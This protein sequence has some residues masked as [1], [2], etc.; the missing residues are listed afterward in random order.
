MLIDIQ[1][2]V[3]D[4]GKAMSNG[5]KK[6]HLSIAV[7]PIE[8]AD[9]A[10]SVGPFAK[11]TKR[12]L[13][14]VADAVVECLAQVP[15]FADIRVE[16]PFVNARFDTNTLFRLA[17][18]AI[19]EK[20]IATKKPERI[21]VEY[22]SPNTNKPLHLGHVRNGVL[23]STLANLLKAAGHHVVRAN[24]INDRGEHI[25]KSMLAYQRFGNGATP[26]SLGQKGD[27]FVGDCYVRY[28]QEADKDTSLAIEVAAMLKKWE[29]G[30]KEVRALW[31]M[32]NGWVYSGFAET[33]DRYGFS[34]DKVYHESLLF[35]LGKDKVDEGLAK[36]V[37]VR[38]DEGA[39]RFPLPV[40]LGLGA[41]GKQRQPKVLNAG[42]TSVYLT[43]DIGTAIMKAEE[44]NLDR[45]IYVVANEQ[46][47]HFMA[48]FEMLKA[49]GHTW[50][51]RCYHLSYA[52][53]ELPEGKMKSRTGRVVDADDLADDMA[54]LAADIIGQREPG[55]DAAEIAR[56]SEV[57]GLTA[58]KFY[59]MRYASTKTISFDPEKSISFEGDTGPYC[60]Y[61]YA[62]ARSILEKARTE[63]EGV[64]STFKPFTRL[65][66]I[67]ERGLALELL[68]LPYN[69][70]RAAD[71]Y[72]PSIL[73]ES[74]LNLAK[75]FNRF[76]KSAQVIS[77]D[78]SLTH[79]RLLL[80]AAAADGLKWGFSLMGIT[81]LE[82]M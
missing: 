59:L 80:V 23:G 5:E 70:R 19:A 49:L 82:K 67:E 13:G 52:M 39:V 36:G 8:K 20:N 48:L 60:L 27:H 16:G 74:M 14:E 4:I 73:V 79:E 26:L 66:S 53:V 2:S 6:A 21:M 68:R 22:L 11:N 51:S 61:T 28:A 40:H 12:S 65:G 50:A 57:V 34:F 24:L 55:L 38:D 64:G 81:P 71:A 46:D 3:G 35:T 30:D 33:L 45:S 47:Y 17:V 43:Q 56:R 15:Y 44:F 18:N 69:V 41:D 77:D 78:E 63:V 58:I 76:Y 9:V 32:M 75:A 10:V 1:T 31:E 54:K 25:C 7:P 62:R 37:F 29:D 42:G 72:A